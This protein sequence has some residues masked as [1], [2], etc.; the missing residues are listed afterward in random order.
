MS[1]DLFKSFFEPVNIVIDEMLP[2]DFTLVNEAD[3]S[4]AF[5]NLAQVEHDVLLIVCMCQ[6]ND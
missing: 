1:K 2:M 3:E 5:V 4:Q 6:S